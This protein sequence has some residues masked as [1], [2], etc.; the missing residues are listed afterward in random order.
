MPTTRGGCERNG[1]ACGRGAQRPHRWPRVRSSGLLI[2]HAGSARS[3]APGARYLSRLAQTPP[4]G[5]GLCTR[6]QRAPPR[7][8]LRP[9]PTPGS[10]Q[11]ALRVRD[12]A[13]PGVGGPSASHPLPSG[14]QTLAHSLPVPLELHTGGERARVRAPAAV[15]D[16]L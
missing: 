11:S 9:A 12:G 1:K 5:W 10:H 2:E 4:V 7:A 3:P 6:G 16:S 8:I 14:E 13:C 15:S